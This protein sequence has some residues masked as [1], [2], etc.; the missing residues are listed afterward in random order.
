VRGGVRVF[1][2]ATAAVAM[3]VPGLM[4]AWV[5]DVYGDAGVLK[6]DEAVAEDQVLVKVVAAAVNP[7]DAKR[8][9]DKFRLSGSQR[10]TP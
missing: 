6:L 4:K 10:N 3:E 8:R 2:L 7:V 9:A 5:Y 1:V